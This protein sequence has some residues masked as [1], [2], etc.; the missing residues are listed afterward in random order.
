MWLMVV[1]FWVGG[2][3]A[4]GGVGVQSVPNFT[5]QQTCQVA[6][7]AVQRSSRQI[8]KDQKLVAGECVRQ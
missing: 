7:E 1:V 8:A 4:G 3:A 6:L 2:G 5:S